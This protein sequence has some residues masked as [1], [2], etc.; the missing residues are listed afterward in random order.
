MSKNLT[1]LLALLPGAKVSGEAAQKIEGITADS[2]K[3][4]PGTLFVCLPGARVDGHNF[5][6]QAHKLGAVAAVVEKDV[7]APAGMT[8]I[9]VADSREAMQAVVPFFYDYPGR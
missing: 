1:Q 9:K 4:A 3:V 6:A 2:R 8:L 5:I 7:P